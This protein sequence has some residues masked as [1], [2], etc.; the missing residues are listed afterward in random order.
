[1]LQIPKVDRANA[2]KNALDVPYLFSRI[3]WVIWAAFLP[4]TGFFG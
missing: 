3:K 2:F 4:S 1:M